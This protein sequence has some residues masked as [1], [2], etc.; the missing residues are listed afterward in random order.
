[1]TTTEKI[2][3]YFKENEDIFNDCIEELDG[4]NGYLGDDRYY[5]MDELSELFSGTDPIDLLNRAFFG[6]DAETWTTNARGEREYGAF[7][8]NRNYFTFSGYGNLVS[9]DYKDYSY[10]LDCY[11]VENLHENRN[12]VYTVNEND[13]LCALFDELEEEET[14]E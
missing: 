4:Y 12:N 11:F 9:S 6:R 2:I 10:F 14:E 3:A 8:P 13:D 7:N 5:Y 1:M